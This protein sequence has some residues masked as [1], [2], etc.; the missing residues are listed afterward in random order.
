[1]N[2]LRVFYWLLSFVRVA[3]SLIS[4][5]IHHW[6]CAHTIQHPFFHPFIRI[7]LIDAARMCFIYCRVKSQLNSENVETETF[8]DQLWAHRACEVTWWHD[9]MDKLMCSRKSSNIIVKCRLQS[10]S[11]VVLIITSFRF[12]PPCTRYASPSPYTFNERTAS[13]RQSN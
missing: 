10:L 12:V 5:T 1:M 7:A 4:A 3:F 8:F 9:N 6:H 2:S 11:F 13:E